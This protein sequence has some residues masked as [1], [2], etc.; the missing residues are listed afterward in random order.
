MKHGKK[1]NPHIIKNQFK[2][3]NSLFF[4]MLIKD[5]KIKT[6]EL[7]ALFWDSAELTL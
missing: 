3:Y 4:S 2:I 7:H 6:K 5:R 1:K